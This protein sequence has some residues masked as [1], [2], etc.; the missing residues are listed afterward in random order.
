M[1]EVSTKHHT[2]MVSLAKR[3]LAHRRRLGYQ[4]R[5]EGAQIE[6]FARYADRIAPRQPLTKTLALQWATLPQTPA[7]GF[8]HAKRVECL[9]GFARFCSVFDSRTEIPATRLIGPAHRRRAPHIY[10]DEQVRVLLQRA[11]ALPVVYRTDP[12]RSLTYGALFGL[13]ACT[14]MRICEALR[15]NVSDFNAVAGTLRVP[16]AKFSPERVIPLHPSTVAT[17]RRYISERAR[18][19]T[20][21]DSMFLGRGGRA[22]RK[23]TVHATFRTLT[24][25]FV[26]N[27][28]RS[29][30]RIHDFRHTLATRLIASWSRQRAPIGHHLLLLSRYLGHRSFSDTFWYV[31][32]D[33]VALGRVSRLL[34]TF[35]H[36]THDS[37]PVPVS[38]PTV[39]RGTLDRPAQRES[40]DRRRVPRHVSPPSSFPLRLPRLRG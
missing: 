35:C 14:G 33:P 16:R 29:R 7:R 32:S 3:Y 9:R 24:G 40:A 18:I 31:S 19:P 12:L 20:V 4:L 13:I 5:T 34:R 27:G 10:T 8:Y 22:L 30:P 26:S 11:A 38:D 28:V 2:S 39:L 36:D 25:D 21:A 17:L 6:D 23:R 37:D 1:A 15:L